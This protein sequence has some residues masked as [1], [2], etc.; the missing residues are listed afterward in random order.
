MD[1][2]TV[3]EQ[4]APIRLANEIA[5]G[6]AEAHR[7]LVRRIK[8]SDPGPVPQDAIETY[9]RAILGVLKGG[10]YTITWQGE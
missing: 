6:T 7:Q 8:G 5:K 3:N 2:R 4:L 1:E 9:A 10:G